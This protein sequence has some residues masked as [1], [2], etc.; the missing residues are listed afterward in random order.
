MSDHAIDPAPG[1]TTS[2]FPESNSS[3]ERAS[4]SDMQQSSADDW[5]IIAA[6]FRPFA[7][8]LPARILAHLRLLDGDCGGFPID[9]LAH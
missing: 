6:E 9:R 8:D 2:D 7:A 5:R 1:H 4:F 3:N